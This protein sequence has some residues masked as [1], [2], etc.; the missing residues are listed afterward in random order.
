MDRITASAQLQCHTRVDV[1][2]FANVQAR[3]ERCFY[4]KATLTQTSRLPTSQRL[5]HAWHRVMPAY[6][7]GSTSR[8]IV[9]TSCVH[10]A[11]GGNKCRCVNCVQW[12]LALPRW[13]VTIV[14]V[15]CEHSPSILKCHRALGAR[16]KKSTAACMDQ[17]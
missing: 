16:V 14:R 7:Q 8:D 12:H 5:L 2:F 9:L 15:G 4:H 3:H 13:P 10:K 17:I 6:R 1:F 11:A